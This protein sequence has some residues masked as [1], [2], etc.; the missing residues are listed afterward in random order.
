MLRR[1]GQAQAHRLPHLAAEQVGS[2]AVEHQ[3][4]VAASGC[5]VPVGQQPDVPHRARSCDSLLGD[6]RLAHIGVSIHRRRSSALLPLPACPLDRARPRLPAPERRKSSVDTR[7]EAMRRRLPARGRLGRHFRDEVDSPQSDLH[8]ECAPEVRE[9][10]GIGQV[11]RTVDVEERLAIHREIAWVEE[12]RLHGTEM[13]EVVIGARIG[14][15]RSESC[16]PAR[17]RR[18]SSSDWP[19]RGRTEEPARESA[20]P[21]PGAVRGS[22]GLRTSSASSRTP[23]PRGCG[24]SR[25]GPPEPRARGDRRSPDQR[26]GEAGSALEEGPRLDHVPPFGEAG[27]PPLVVLGNGV[28]LRQVEGDDAHCSIRLRSR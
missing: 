24:P 23:R 9:P 22:A 3:P 20:A 19:T 27:T 10:Q 21:P 7:V 26:G 18:R 5:V 4:V 17:A 16:L 6:D 28:E 14:L 1:G 25:P 13:R 2:R 11:A 8:R 15:S 12:C